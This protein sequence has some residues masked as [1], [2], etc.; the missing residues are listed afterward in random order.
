MERG[1]I[2]PI[3]YGV[4]EAQ[5]TILSGAQGG[6]ERIKKTPLPFG[7][8][9]LLHRTAHV[10]CML[11]PFA[12]A[13][14]LGW[15]TILLTLIIAYTFFGLDALSDEL[16]DPFGNDPNDLPLTAIVRGVERELLAATGSTT[17]PP[18]IVAQNYV[19]S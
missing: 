12:L 13:S 2:G 4:L 3:H 18:P 1:R 9:L 10:Y 6:C 11:L 15:W 17:L 16:G 19:L 14:S 7:Y 8:S 5:L